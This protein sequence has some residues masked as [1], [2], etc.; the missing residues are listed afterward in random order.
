MIL[1]GTGH[2]PEDCEA[3]DIV[4]LKS[5]L[6]IKRSGA[7]IFISGMAAGLDLWAA[8]EARLLGVEIWAAKPWAGHHARKG[9]EELYQRIIDSATKVVDVVESEDFPG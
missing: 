6:G 7:D 8:D 3:E 9:D 5:R 4:R 2:R 1:C